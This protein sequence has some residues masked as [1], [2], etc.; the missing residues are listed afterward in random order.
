[1]DALI[2]SFPILMVIVTMLAFGLPAKTALPLG[3]LATFAV[4]V[5]YWRQDLLTSCAWAMDGFL[6]SA[7]VLS[8]VFGAILVMNT[9]K[10]SGA[11]SAIQRGF[12]GITPD[13][14]IQTVIVGY[15]FAAFIEGAAGFGSSAAL[16]APLL[17]SLGFPPLCAVIVTLIF[18]S[19]PVS[20]GAVGTP[21]TTAANLSGANVMELARYTAIGNGSAAFWTLAVALF[22]VCRMFGPRRRGRDALAAFPFALFTVIVFDVFYIGLAWTVGPEFPSV[23]GS[24]PTLALSI[25]FAKKGWLCPKT[26][27]DFERREVWEQSW[28]STVPVK[29][30]VDSGM[31][32]IRAWLPYA[33]IA[34]A[35]LAAR[36]DWFGF[37]GFLTSAAFTLRIDHVLGCKDVAWKWNW[38]WSPGFMPFALVCALTFFL[39][40]MPGPKIREVLCDVWK[41]GM[42]AV[43]TI[44]F[45]VSMAYIYR[46]TGFN[47]A[48][49]SKSMVYVMAEALAG[50]FQQAYVG[51]AP[52]IGVLGAFM[53]GSNTVSNM[54]FASLQYEIAVSLGTLSPVVV[55][56]LQNI[57]G[58]AGNMICVNNVV[59]VCATTGVSGCEGRI[60]RTNLIPCFVYCLVAILVLGLLA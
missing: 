60:I 2:A 43:V 45:G 24:I 16:A 41:Q 10:H 19:V 27:W 28:L 29:A 44:G 40:R 9:L 53:S 8:V 3:W 20:F 7:S 49:T 4:A 31:S 55:L 59:A 5:G 48:L 37:K 39:H 47:A 12:N 14:R 46:N 34:V 1:M 13:R 17:I 35:L 25:L 26:T 33:L 30:N 23:L 15:A 52:F 6:E 54:L 42:G 11:L 18:N 56:A 57:G 38:G 58:A 36:L 22:V 50:T 51:V 21:T 32:Q